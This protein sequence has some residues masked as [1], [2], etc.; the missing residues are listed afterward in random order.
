MNTP[1]KDTHRSLLF[2]LISDSIC[3]KGG[4]GVFFVPARPLR[5]PG[6]PGTEETG[7]RQT[8]TGWG[9]SN[10][11][12]PASSFWVLCVAA[13]AFSSVFLED[14]L[15]WSYFFSCSFLQMGYQQTSEFPPQPHL[16]SPFFPHTDVQLFWSWYCP[17]PV[18][19]LPRHSPFANRYLSR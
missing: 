15:A 2:L 8:L 9:R 19:S 17:G 7:G 11:W 5:G 13:G 1:H 16:C 18:P 3:Q 4:S 14:S 10:I 6:Q 12:L